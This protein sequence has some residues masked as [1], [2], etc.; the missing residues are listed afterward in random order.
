MLCLFL[1]VKPTV[2][3]LFYIFT[4]AVFTVGYSDWILTRLGVTKSNNQNRLA[5]GMLLGIG[6]AVLVYIILDNYTNL[7]PYLIAIIFISIALIVKWISGKN[8]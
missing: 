8:R 7:V 1:I 3:H 2:N 4:T 6:G 5:S